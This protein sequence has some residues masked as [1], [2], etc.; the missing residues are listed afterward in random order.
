MKTNKKASPERRGGTA[1]AVTE[2]YQK[3]RLAVA[4]KLSASPH[5]ASARERAVWVPLSHFVTAP[6]SG[7]AYFFIFTQR[8]FEMDDYKERWHSECCDGEVSFSHF[9]HTFSMLKHISIFCLT[10]KTYI[11]PTYI[12]LLSEIF[13]FQYKTCLFF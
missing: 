11:S 7:R 8:K 6:L 1:N 10:A 2:R 5:F 4:D 9:R 12:L 3:Q 13:K